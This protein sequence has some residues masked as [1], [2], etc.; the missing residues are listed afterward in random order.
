[1]ALAAGPAFA[2]TNLLPN[3]GFE[4]AGKGTIAGWKGVRAALTLR[5]DGLGGGHAA[6]VGRTSGAT[7]S[8]VARPNPAPAAAGRLYRARGDVRSGRPGRTVCLKLVELTPS[9]SIAGQA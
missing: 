2:A 9:G 8:I 1:V 3:G 7:Y 6:R 4:N 5:P